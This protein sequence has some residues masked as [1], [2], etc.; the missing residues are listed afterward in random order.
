MV[1]HRHSRRQ[2][3]TSPKWAEGL[4]PL[5]RGP[6]PR[7]TSGRLRLTVAR[8]NVSALRALQP[9]C[10]IGLR[11]FV[12]FISSAAPTT[13]RSI[14]NVPA[15]ATSDHARPRR[16]PL[17]VTIRIDRRM[18]SFERHRPGSIRLEGRT[19]FRICCASRICCRCIWR[20]RRAGSWWSGVWLVGKV[21][22]APWPRRS[23]FRRRV[24]ASHHIAG[25]WA[26]LRESLMPW[27]GD[28]CIR[29]ELDAI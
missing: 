6:S 24:G 23:K 27:T 25:P 16:A 9:Q 18:A 19:S 15:R 5:G 26:T 8:P 29:I 22:A 1:L 13:T 10:R 2:W 4:Q 21:A 17:T 7:G 14:P 11:R 28:N 20:R 3:S 12:R